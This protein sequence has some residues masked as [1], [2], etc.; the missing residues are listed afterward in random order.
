MTSFILDSKYLHY[1]KKKYVIA[2]LKGRAFFIIEK[3]N[4]KS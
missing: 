3:I 4:Y 2:I 1:L